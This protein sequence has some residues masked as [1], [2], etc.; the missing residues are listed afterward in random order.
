MKKDILIACAVAAVAAFCFGF[1]SYFYPTIPSPGL[2]TGIL[3]VL[4]FAI[5]RVRSS[6]R[7]EVLL[8]NA[9]R[10]SSLSAVAPAG[11]ALLYIY[12]DGFNGRL[13]GWDV[14]LDGAALAHVRSPRFTQTTLGPGPHTLTVSLGDLAGT[15]NK[16]AEATFEAQAGDVIVIAMNMKLT[17]GTLGFVREQDVRTALQKFSKMPMVAANRPAGTTAA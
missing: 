5:R 13:V 17:G 8:D 7:K 1:L 6:S 10:R 4:V 14:S 16:P 3:L 15:K 11:Q 9:T 12:R 2:P